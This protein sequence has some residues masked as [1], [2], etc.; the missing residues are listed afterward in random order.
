MNLFFVVQNHLFYMLAG[1]IVDWNELLD[2]DFVRVRYQYCFV[3]GGLERV[4]FAFL[5]CSILIDG[6]S[7][8]LPVHFRSISGSFPV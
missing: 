3:F 6:S 1:S 8:G 4:H 5:P 2:L 7:N